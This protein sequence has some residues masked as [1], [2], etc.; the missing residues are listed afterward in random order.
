MPKGTY[1]GLDNAKCPFCKYDDH[2]AKRIVCEGIVDKSWLALN[3]HHKKD[4]DTQMNV[5][6]CE[7]YR[8]CEIYR[9]LME[10]KYDM[11][12]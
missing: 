1:K 2:Q 10:N 7:H 9:M 12:V 8:K 6:C 11:E 5:F 3:Y 4:Y